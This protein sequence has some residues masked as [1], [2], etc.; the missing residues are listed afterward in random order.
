VTENSRV[1]GDL[2]VTKAASARISGLFINGDLQLSENTGAL[3]A[4]RAQV[5]GN[6]QVVKNRG[7]VELLNNT[8]A[9]TLQC[10]ENT[11]A[12]TG[13]GNV[14]GDKEDQCRAL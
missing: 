14:A 8:I 5:R 1:D 9:Q 6:V 7:G 13:S 10:V 2:Q 11:P 3:F 12:P 4:S